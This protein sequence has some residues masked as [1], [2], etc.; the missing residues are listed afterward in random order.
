M[1]KASS[2]KFIPIFLGLI[3]LFI[4]SMVT[5]SSE[6]GFSD[7]YDW[8]FGKD[9]SIEKIYILEK[10]RWDRTWT[11]FLVGASLSLAGLLLQ[12]LLN[13]PL[14]EPYTL[15]LSGGASLGV[16]LA[17]IFLPFSQTLSLP[18]GGFIGCLIVTLIIGRIAIRESISVSYHLI[19]FGVMISL[20]CG[21]LVILTLSLFEPSQLQTAF[22]WM[23]GRAGT[24]RDYWWPLLAI[25][26]CLS[27]CW[28][29]S[30]LYVL[31]KLLLGDEIAHSL[32]VEIKKLRLEIIIVVGLLT[33]I[34][35]SLMGLVGFVG[36][37]APHLSTLITGTRK[38]LQNII[39]SLLLGGGLLLGADIIGRYIGGLKEIPA[40]S[41]VALIGAPFLIFLLFQE[42]KYHV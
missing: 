38:H 17:M 19:L 26:L 2:M 4:L 42:R 23:V 8:L 14:A 32:N 7:I 37:I 21:S 35:A 29:L 20:F 6:T 22:L 9:I 15:G 13:N 39:G 5:G 41:L 16:V 12:T 40:G 30:R 28:S 18:I 31:D 3:I 33:A 24:E 36:L 27:I 11:C 1:R 25:T 10:L 34:S